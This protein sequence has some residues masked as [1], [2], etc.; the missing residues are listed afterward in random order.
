MEQLP[1]AVAAFVRE[2]PPA[3]DYVLFADFRGTPAAGL[4]ELRAVVVDKTGAIAWAERQAA[5]DDTFK[6]A[7][8]REPMTMALLL[9]ERLGPQFG[10]DAATARAAKPGK[11]ARLMEE[12]SGLPP[13]EER[14]ALAPRQK[15]FVSA[16]PTA[17]LLV[18]P[19]VAPDRT[20]NEIAARIANGI[21]DARLFKSA[22]APAETK[23]LPPPRPDPNEMKV[24]WDLAR[25]ARE[26]VKKNPPSA[27]YVVCA[28]YRFNPKNWERGFLHF[29]VCDRQGDW[30]IV[31]LQNSHQKDYQAIKPVSKEACEELLLKRLSH[32]LHPE[33]EGM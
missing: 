29:V 31:D 12:R 8:A 5:D 19:V 23:A 13:R 27:D 4:N 3:T 22:S 14:D 9:V 32:Y 10:L 7:H 16:A 33:S 28:D 6:Q 24:L 2:N 20:E 25:M 30:V 1:E 11:F 26:Q 17:T 21:N 15:T 18:L